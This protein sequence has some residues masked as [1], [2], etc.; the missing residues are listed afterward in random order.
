[1]TGDLNTLKSGDERAWSAFFKEHDSLLH[2]VASWNKWRFQHHEINEVVQD[3]RRQLPKSIQ[4]FKGDSTLT[5]FIKRIA[6]HVCI[7]RVRRNVREKSRF[8]LMSTLSNE[9]EGRSWDPPA[10]PEFDPVTAII[11]A[12]KASAI[13]QLLNRMDHTCSNAIT[14]FYLKDHSYKE[15]AAQLGIAVNTVGSRLAKCLDK[16]REMATDFSAGGE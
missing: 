5:Y 13:R 10:G 8:V 11:D 1:M 16:L 6:I 7:D 12:E 9:E 2:S 14:L 3:V 4:T 15:M